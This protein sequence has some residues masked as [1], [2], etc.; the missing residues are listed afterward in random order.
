MNILDFRGKIERYID[1]GFNQKNYILMLLDIGKT[2]EPSLG[3][4]IC[5]SRKTF[6]WETAFASEFIQKPFCWWCK[7]G[8][9]SK[10]TL[11]QHYQIVVSWETQSI[12]QVF[13]PESQEIEDICFCPWFSKNLG[14]DIVPL[15]FL[16]PYSMSIEG[17]FTFNQSQDYEGFPF[18]TK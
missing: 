15:N 9:H 4:L 2:W 11:G 5:T 18:K 17:H 8:N 10:I 1:F 3:I 14:F 12:S 7:W 6:L 16:S 13:P